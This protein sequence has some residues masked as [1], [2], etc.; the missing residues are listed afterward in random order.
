M[1]KLVTYFKNGTVKVI[2]WDTLRPLLTPNWLKLREK[3]KYNF[4]ILRELRDEYDYLRYCAM[5]SNNK[6]VNFFVLGSNFYGL[7]M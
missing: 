4:L 2:E 6:T 5:K 7:P 1:L 3:Y